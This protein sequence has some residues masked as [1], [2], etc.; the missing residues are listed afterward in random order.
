[1][2]KNHFAISSD[3]D[4]TFEPIGTQFETQLKCL[5]GVLGSMGTSASVSKGD[6]FINEGG[7]TLLHA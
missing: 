7:Q 4:I 3:P 2:I 6:G 5:D 1:M